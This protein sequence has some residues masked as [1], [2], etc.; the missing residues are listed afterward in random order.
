[1]D[2]GAGSSGSEP[3]V[4]VLFDPDSGSNVG[5]SSGCGAAGTGSPAL[6]G[7]C[8]KTFPQNHDRPAGQSRKED[9]GATVR[10]SMF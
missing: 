4:G 3:F 2:T 9:Y 6:P 5:T 7:S 1:M 10:P 8:S